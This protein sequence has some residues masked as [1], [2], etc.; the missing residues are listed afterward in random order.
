MPHRLHKLVGL[1]DTRK[2]RYAEWITSIP[3][4]I[5]YLSVGRAVTVAADDGAINVWDTRNGNYRCEIYRYQTTVDSQSF[6]NLGQVR[7]WLKE[8]MPRIYK[9]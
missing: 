3:F 1:P 2:V 6:T 5:K 8:W 4:A 9:D 7:K